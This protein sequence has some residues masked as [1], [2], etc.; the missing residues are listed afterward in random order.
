MATTTFRKPKTWAKANLVREDYQNRHEYRKAA[1][2]GFKTYQ[3]NNQAAKQAAKEAAKAAKAAELSA[4]P[5]PKVEK[6]AAPAPKPEKAAKPL[7]KM[8]KAELLAYIADMQ[9]KA[10]TRNQPKEEPKPMATP[11]SEPKPKTRAKEQSAQEE[12]QVMYGEYSEK[13]MV[14]FGATKAIKDDLKALGGVFN[15]HLNINGQRQPGWIFPKKNWDNVAKM[16]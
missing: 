1:A 13:S 4:K 3:D 2:I 5:L 8:T 6:P 9:P 15:P 16:F 14:V 12:T 7:D 11:K 10:R